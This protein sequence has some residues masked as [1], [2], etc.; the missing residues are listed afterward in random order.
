MFTLTKVTNLITLRISF[1][2]RFNKVEALLRIRMKAKRLL[3]LIFCFANLLNYGATQRRRNICL[4]ACLP[5]C[6][7]ASYLSVDFSIMKI[8]PEIEKL[9]VLEKN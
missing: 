4:P 3:D 5:A 2:I 6:Y 7:L 9:G 1:A 8:V